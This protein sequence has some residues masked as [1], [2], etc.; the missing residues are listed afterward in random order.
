MFTHLGKTGTLGIRLP[1]D[2]REAFLEKLLS[3]CQTRY[4][5]NPWPKIRFGYVEEPKVYVIKEWIK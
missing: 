4:D 2:E 3:E 1:E 5:Y